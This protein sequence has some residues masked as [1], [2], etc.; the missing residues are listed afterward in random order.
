MTKARVK[1]RKQVMKDFEEVIDM[2]NINYSKEKA[3]ERLDK[4]IK[5]KEDKKGI[6]KDKTIK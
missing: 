6:K 3:I 1:D 2:D 5:K 4:F